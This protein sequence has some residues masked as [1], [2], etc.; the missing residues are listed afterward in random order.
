LYQE[1]D[2]YLFDDPFSAVDAHTGSHL[3]K[4]RDSLYLSS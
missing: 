2:I 4:V 3:F 1:A